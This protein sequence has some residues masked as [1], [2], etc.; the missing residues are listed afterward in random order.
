MLKIITYPGAAGSWEKFNI[1][2]LGW[3]VIIRSAEFLL[4]SCVVLLRA[5]SFLYPLEL[6]TEQEERQHEIEQ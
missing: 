2:K 5:I 1:C 6:P 4:P 3:M